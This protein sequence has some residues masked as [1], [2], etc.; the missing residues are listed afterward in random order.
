MQDASKQVPRDHGNAQR[1]IVLRV[2]EHPDGLPLAAL[3][4]ELDDL[5]QNTLT[6]AMA[7]LQ[8]EGVVVVDDERVQASRCARRLDTLALICV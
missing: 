3:Y 4:T 8:A 2:L 1:V 6:D 5:D 7:S